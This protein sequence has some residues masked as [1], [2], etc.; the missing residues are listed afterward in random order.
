MHPHDVQLCGVVGSTAYG[1]SHPGSDIDRLGVFLAPTVEVLGLGAAAAVSR[2][3]VSTNP[4]VSMH[5]LGKYCS[6]ALAANPTVL[7]LLYCTAYERCTEVGAEL[8]EN[9][10]AFLS[11]GRVRAAYVG[12]AVSQARKATARAADGRPGFSA[13]TAKRIAKHGRHC[14]RLLLMAEQL[15]TTGSLTLD[16]SE[17]RDELFAAG[18]LA[19]CDP[20]AFCAAVA[21][22]AARIDALRS[23]LPEHPD[24][25][26][27]EKIVV[28][29]RTAQ[30]TA[31]A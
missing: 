27:V 26:R 9:R 28:A 22:R 18:E 29:A 20:D 1:L 10:D 11:A 5:E 14:A 17:H 31:V 12:Y 24:V 19:E 23:V 30:S 8:V 3:R 2:S 16:V 25:D 13:D 6:L 4:D 15:L 7:E 21:V